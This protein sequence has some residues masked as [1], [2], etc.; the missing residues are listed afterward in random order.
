[1][2]NR[3]GDSFPFFSEKNEEKGMAQNFSAF[4]KLSEEELLSPFFLFY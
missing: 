2:P 4:L 1:M 3:S